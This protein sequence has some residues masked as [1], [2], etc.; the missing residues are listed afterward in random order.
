MLSTYKNF[1]FLVLLTVSLTACQ[2]HSANDGH[3]HGSADSHSGHGHGAHEEGEENIARLTTAQIETIGLE[4]GAFTEMKIT[5]FVKANGVLDLP[6][7]EIATVSAPAEGYVRNIREGY[8]IGSYIKKGAVLAT[9][10]HPK[11][12]QM[13]QSYL[14]VQAEL[15]YTKL[16]K[17]RQATLTTANA[18]ALKKL[19]EATSKLKILEAKEQSLKKQIQ[20]LGISID[21][22]KQGDISST[23]ALVAPISGYI[24]ELNI[25]Q[26]KYI[27][28]QERLYE[29]V[30][31]N[32]IHL[33]LDIF[34]KDIAQIEEGQK[35]SF[36]I[37]ALDNESYE[38][39]VKL[40]GKAFDMHTKTVRVHGHV[41]GKNP[42]FLRGSYIEAKIWTTGN[43][44]NALPEEAIVK[45]DGFDYIFIQKSADEKGTE[46]EM[47][48][49]KTGKSEDGF[50]H[51]APLSPLPKDAVIALNQAYFIA[52]DMTKAEHEHSH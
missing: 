50:V 40:I 3:G 42:K 43:K 29:I 33:E 28:P 47:I 30:N 2:Q 52:S 4:M 35:I 38:G 5:G 20:Y 24:T 25:N 10:E 11:Y 46:F 41:D 8:L 15:E 14:E 49:V 19:Q 32:H 39:D 37:P 12:I 16:E 9:I 45:K 18:G 36:T 13:Q 27:T 21:K 7:E 48:R 34:E 17:E 22:V 51:V 44:V 23:I 31:N 6:P 26:G 1:I